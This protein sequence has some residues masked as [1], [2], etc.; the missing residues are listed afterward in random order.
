MVV[1]VKLWDAFVTPRKLCSPVFFVARKLREGEIQGK[2]LGG[3][4]RNS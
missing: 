4:E 2:W 3:E 1:V